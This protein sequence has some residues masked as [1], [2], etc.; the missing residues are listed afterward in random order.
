MS[1]FLDCILPRELMLTKCTPYSGLQG[2][3]NHAAVHPQGR[4]ALSVGK[5]RCLR[6]W[7]LLGRSTGKSSTSTKL[8]AEADLVR[9]NIDGTRLAVL[10]DRQVRVFSTVS[11]PPTSMDVLDGSR[12]A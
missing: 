11:R 2:R 10:L 1:I 7:D 5:D 3:V 12:S 4:V 8:G 6:M 9:W